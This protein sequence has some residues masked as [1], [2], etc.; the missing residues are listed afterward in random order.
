MYRYV[1]FL[2][3]VSWPNSSNNVCEAVKQKQ[4]ATTATKTTTTKNTQVE[5]D[6][7][8]PPTTPERPSLVLE[9]IKNNRPIY[10]FGLGSNM[11]REKV[12]NRAVDGSKIQIQSMK[13]AVVPNYRLAFNMRGFPPLEPGMGSLEPVPTSKT[14]SDDNNEDAT[15][16]KPLLAYKN[17][18]CHGALIK[19]TPENYEKIMRS[20]GVGS[21]SGNSDQG[22]EEIVVEA[23]PYDNSNS[24]LSKFLPSQRQ[25]PVLAVALRAKEKS[26][27]DVDPCPSERYM[28]I[29]RTGAK[30]L[31]L[32]EC[33]QE[34]LQQHPVQQT[35]Q[36]L[37]KIAVY[38]LLTT[39]TLSFKLKW[40]GISRIQSWF[41][42]RVS[43][44]P[45]SPSSIAKLCSDVLTATI[46]LP[47]AITAF[48]GISLI[49][50]T[51]KEVPPMVTRIKQ[52]LGGEEQE[53][54]KSTK[55]T[56]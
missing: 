23:Y 11:L 34:F 6:A 48:V 46:L 45:T 44:N 21:G 10:Y 25:Q 32:K 36:W 29:L 31:G 41:L 38:N 7:S 14:S 28:T 53:E 43:V 17:P 1:L 16:S 56:D 52:R 2:L 51:G 42:Y 13:P 5:N 40:R 26:R 24:L 20:E 37:K 55:K 19:V 4:P 50:L 39:F 18:E 12:E 3:L 8:T 15:Y 47:G 33:Y 22:Y 30:E 9:S 54:D 35:P 49:E 27:L